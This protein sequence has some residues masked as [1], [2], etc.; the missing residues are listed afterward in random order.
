MSLSIRPSSGWM[1]SCANDHRVLQTPAGLKSSSVCSSLPPSLVPLKLVSSLARRLPMPLL[2]RE[3]SVPGLGGEGGL[4]W[5]RE[6]PP[7]G[8]QMQIDENFQRDSPG[9]G[10]R[11][12]RSEC[13]A[14]RQTQHP[15]RENVPRE[16]VHVIGACVRRRHNAGEAVC[17]PRRGG[18]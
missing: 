16:A 2:P 10:D 18:E 6:P 1:P 17:G 5:A 11:L 3:G 9:L 12:Q 15:R 14:I 13:A 4:L 8:S 7:K